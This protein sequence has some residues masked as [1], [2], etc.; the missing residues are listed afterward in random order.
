MF[1]KW[2][3]AHN[4]NAFCF[5]YESLFLQEEKKR[6][7]HIYYTHKI[8]WNENISRWLLFKLKYP[9]ENRI[10][11]EDRTKQRM[12]REKNKKKKSEKN[13]EPSFWCTI[14]VYGYSLCGARHSD[15]FNSRNFSLLVLCSIVCQLWNR[16]HRHTAS[17]LNIEV[18]HGEMQWVCN[19]VFCILCN[20]VPHFSRY[21]SIPHAEYSSKYCNEFATHRCVLHG[22]YEHTKS[23]CSRLSCKSNW[24]DG[25]FLCVF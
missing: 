15:G 3:C 4:V 17:I 25:V 12:K 14:N 19:Y 6:R 5:A 22:S 2:F 21:T 9:C 8:T 23:F 18:I 24:D 10:R 20:V 1:S 13:I 7:A 16:V 11:L